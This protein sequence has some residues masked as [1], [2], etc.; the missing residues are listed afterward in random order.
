MEVRDDNIRV[1]DVIK[2]DNDM[3]SKTGIYIVTYVGNKYCRDASIGED[4]I[5]KH[6]IVSKKNISRNGPFHKIGNICMAPIDRVRKEVQKNTVASRIREARAR[7]GMDRETLA[8]ESGLCVPTITAYEN[9]DRW[10][11]LYSAVIIADALGVSVDYLA[12]RTKDG[13]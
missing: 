5:V 13:E 6:G 4:G 3:F 1:G 9:G 11:S 8:S 12:G 2:N 10:P 7:A